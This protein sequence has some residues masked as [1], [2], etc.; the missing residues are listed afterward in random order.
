MKIKI[1]LSKKERV[2]QLEES[3]G[4]SASC[5]VMVTRSLLVRRKIV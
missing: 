4:F 5:G 3:M 1:F 2:V